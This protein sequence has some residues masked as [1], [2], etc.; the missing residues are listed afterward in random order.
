MIRAFFT[1]FV[2]FLLL[3]TWLDDIY[4]GGQ[5]PNDLS[6]DCSFSENDTYL[7]SEAPDHCSKRDVED[8]PLLAETF[9]PSEGRIGFSLGSCFMSSFRFPQRLVSLLYVFMSLQR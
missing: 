4:L 8:R 7:P 5:T 3:I 2:A 9:R 1:C 6:D